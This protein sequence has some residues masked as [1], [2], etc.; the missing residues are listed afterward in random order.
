MTDIPGSN[1]K[2]DVAEQVPATLYTILVNWNGWQDTIFCVESLMKESHPALTVVVCDNA[3]HDSS[4]EILTKWADNALIRKDPPISRPYLHR[5]KATTEWVSER[6]PGFRF[7]L[8]ANQDNLG[9]AGGNN[10]GI[11]LALAD[12]SCDY[13]FILNNDTEVMTGALQALEAKANADPGLAIVGA[14]LVFHE[15]PEVVQ[16]LGAAYDRKRARARTLFAGGALDSLPPVEEIEREIEYVI[17]AAMFIRSNVLRRTKGLSEDYFLYYEELDFSKKLKPGERLGWAPDACIRHKVGGSIGT[18][19]A[20]GRPSN[21]SLYYDHRSKIRFYR[22]Y[23]REMTPFLVIGITKT[24][25]A[26]FS[27]GDIVAVRVIL[28]AIRDYLTKN[29]EYRADLSRF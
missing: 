17:G 7:V 26:Y 15:K 14:T 1:A 18:G 25:L 21:T 20:N 19:R 2:G 3:S 28:S 9:F 22:T 13:I 24:I 10:V 16:G 5:A 6:K 12:P 27:K 8:I 23:W 4:V 11:E 29:K